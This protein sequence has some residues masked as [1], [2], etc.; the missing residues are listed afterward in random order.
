M[1]ASDSALHVLTSPVPVLVEIEI[2]DVNDMAPS[3]I[4]QQ[5]NATLL[6]PTV[7]GEQEFHFPLASFYSQTLA[8]NF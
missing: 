3:F 6:L 2:V 5:Y 4:Q 7:K 8:Y 1:E